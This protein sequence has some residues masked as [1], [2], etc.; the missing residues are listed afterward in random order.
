MNLIDNKISFILN[1]LVN[2]LS[3]KKFNV[4]WIEQCMEFIIVVLMIEMYLLNN[5][6]NF[7]NN[8]LYFQIY[9]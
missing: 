9:R 5:V 4:F 6:K 1:N 8:L 2:N 7:S 3:F